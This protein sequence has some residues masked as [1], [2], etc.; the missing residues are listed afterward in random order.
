MANTQ[1]GIATG[2]F[3][4]MSISLLGISIVGGGAIAN[5]NGA[6]V[7]FQ[8]LSGILPDLNTKAYALGM[9]LTNLADKMQQAINT[10][11]GSSGGSGV[12]GGGGGGGG[13]TAIQYADG[14]YTGDGMKQ[15]VA[16]VTVHKGEYVV[17]QHGTLVMKEGGDKDE[18]PYGVMV[19]EL[20]AI[21]K[22]LQAIRA[23]GPGRVTANIHTNAPS[24]N[25]STITDEQRT[26]TRL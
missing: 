15:Q 2:N 9:A 21:K 10:S 11:G 12:G 1:L 26:R 13:G 14:G 22:E 19:I 3:F 20:R 23:M 4:A 18:A 16:N 8:T 5:I 7:A 25:T 6:G 17:P 24:I